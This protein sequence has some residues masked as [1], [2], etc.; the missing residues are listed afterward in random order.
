MGNAERID[1]A[2]LE[3]KDQELEALKSKIQDMKTEKNEQ[4]QL[5]NEELSAR[6]EC[7][8]E[9][10]LKNKVLAELEE[11]I[12]QLNAER[13]DPVDLECK[14]N[15]LELKKEIQDIKAEKDEQNQ[16]MEKEISAKKECEKE[17][18]HKNG[19]IAE[20]E[21]Q[22]RQLDAE[23]SDP[24]DLERKNLELEELKKEVQNIKSE[25]DEQN[26]LMQEEFSARKKCEKEIAKK[27][28]ILAELKEQICYLKAIH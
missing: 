15:E 13:I 14:I 6:K 11:Q 27:D 16:L 18:A 10:T 2:G 5:I 23:R 21:E 7:E 17:I 24:A 20:L 28:Q 12:R 19:V 9:M 26:K 4:I 3:R 8:K 25:K 22:I 1:P